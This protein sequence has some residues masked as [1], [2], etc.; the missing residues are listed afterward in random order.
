MPCF[1]CWYYRSEIKPSCLWDQ[2]FIHWVIPYLNFKLLINQLIMEDVDLVCIFK[3]TMDLLRY[4][5]LKEY[6]SLINHLLCRCRG[7]GV[8]YAKMCV[9][10]ISYETTYR[11]WFSSFTIGSWEWSSIRGLAAWAVPCRVILLS[12]SAFGFCDKISTITSMGEGREYLPYTST[13]QPIT[14]GSQGRSSRQELKQRLQRNVEYWL[15][16]HGLLSYLWL[17]GY[18]PG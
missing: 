6:H 5:N 15:A 8:T 13:S 1:L 11:T 16:L 10:V 7:W 17:Q 4:G 18:Y 12:W 2:H 3:S 9:C 14:E